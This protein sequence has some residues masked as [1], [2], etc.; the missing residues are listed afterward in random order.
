MAGTG[1]CA[2]DLYMA[3]DY[4]ASNS[5]HQDLIK[6]YSIPKLSIHQKSLLQNWFVKIR[7]I[8]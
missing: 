2:I 4:K 7:L 6:Y 1:E 5:V 8:S 3:N